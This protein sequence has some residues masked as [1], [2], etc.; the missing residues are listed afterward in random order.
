VS[1]INVFDIIYL[2]QFRAAD[3]F[4]YEIHVHVQLIIPTLAGKQPTKMRFGK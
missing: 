2:I 3:F 4:T 1:N